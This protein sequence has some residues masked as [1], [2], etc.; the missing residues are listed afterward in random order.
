MEL[1]GPAG[2][3]T[4]VRTTTSTEFEGS[5]YAQRL[6]ISSLATYKQW[7]VDNNLGNDARY[8]ANREAFGKAHPVVAKF[9]DQTPEAKE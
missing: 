8:K 1:E 7:K 4:P 6:M 3:E 2:V 5:L 9:L